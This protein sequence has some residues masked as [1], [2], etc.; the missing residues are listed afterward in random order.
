[1]APGK[2]VAAL[3]QTD[4][5]VPAKAA[6]V[7]AGEA[8]CIGDRV[9]GRIEIG[10]AASFHAEER[11]GEVLVV[12]RDLVRVEIAAHRPQHGLVDDIG[13]FVTSERGVEFAGGIHP[14]QSVK[15]GLVEVN[16]PGCPFNLRQALVPGLVPV[17]IPDGV[18]I[19]GSVLVTPERVD[20]RLHVVADDPVNGHQIGVQVVDDRPRRLDGKKYRAAAQEGL[21]V[22][23]GPLGKQREDLVQKLALAA[24]PFYDRSNQFV[25]CHLLR[26]PRG[27]LPLL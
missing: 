2:L 21:A 24:N 27:Q 9:V 8:R 14:E 20:Q 23:G 3:L 5:L 16:Q 22:D 25:L 17:H 12:E 10:E 6:L 15:T 11:F 26:L 18:E 7:I 4:L 19:F 13:V 1:M